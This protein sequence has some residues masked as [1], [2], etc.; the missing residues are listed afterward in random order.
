MAYAQLAG[1]PVEHGLYAAFLPVALAALWG[2]S[3][4][5]STGPVAIIS[6]MTAAALEPLAASSPEQYLGY[7][8]TLTVLAGV[9][10]L[11]LGLFPK[12]ATVIA[13]IPLPVLGGAGLCMFGMVAATG[14]KILSRADFEKRHNLLIV[15]VSIAVGMIPLVAPTFFNQLPKWLDAIVHSGITLAAISAVVLNAL[16]NGG[17]S[18]ADVNRE[19]AAAASAGGEH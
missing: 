1:L 16:F 2:S 17:G 5:L 7:V 4:Q 19:L 14:I 12:M 3:R 8:L 15:A 6:L 10:L 18:S 11:A 9:I 13:S